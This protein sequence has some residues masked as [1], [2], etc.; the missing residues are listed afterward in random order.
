MIKA[1]VKHPYNSLD[2]IKGE[3][4]VKHPETPYAQ[5]GVKHRVKHLK[6]PRG[7]TVGGFFKN[8]N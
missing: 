7:E 5:Q 4:E 3:R 6:Q 1:G 2:Q 8:P